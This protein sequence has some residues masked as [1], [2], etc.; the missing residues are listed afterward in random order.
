M[1]PGL[2]RKASPSACA[3]PSPWRRGRR[4]SASVFRQ[5]GG[6]N[7]L[8]QEGGEPL[9]HRDSRLIHL[10]M[11]CKFKIRAG[12]QWLQPVSSSDSQCADAHSVMRRGAHQGSTLR[13]SRNHVPCIRRQSQLARPWPQAR[14]CDV[15]A[16]PRPLIHSAAAASASRRRMHRR[17]SGVIRLSGECQRRDAICPAIAVTAATL[18]PSASSTGPCSM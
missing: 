17:G 14:R 11:H 6:F 4:R 13:R 5:S 2:R 18:N 10:R 9:V 8:R 1:P 3:P 16:I 15:P 7:R 12:W